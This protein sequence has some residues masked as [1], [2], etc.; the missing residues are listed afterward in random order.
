MKKIKL[1]PM[2]SASGKCMQ[3][4]AAQYLKDGVNVVIVAANKKQLRKAWEKFTG[5]PLIE[6]MTSEVAIFSKSSL[7]KSKKNS[8]NARRTS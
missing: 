1:T 5:Y 7:V 3:G 4:V 8:G 6:D 2:E